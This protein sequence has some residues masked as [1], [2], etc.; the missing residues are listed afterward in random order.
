MFESYPV[1]TR[2]LHVDDIGG[3][4]HIYGKRNERTKQPPVDDF[5]EKC[6]TDVDA[7]ASIK[8][9]RFFFKNKY[10]WSTRTFKEPSMIR[11]TFTGLPNYM[12]RVDAVYEAYN[13]RKIWFFMG[14]EIYI[15][16]EA[17]LI[18]RK[19]LSD[20][21]ID[22]QKYRKIDA[23]F[24][25]NNRE[26]I[27]SGEVYWRLEKTYNSN[28][29]VEKG[30]PKDRKAV[31]KNVYDI[32]TAFSEDGQLN[33]FE[34]LYAYKFDPEKMSG[35]R[36]NLKN[37]ASFMDCKNIKSTI[38]NDKGKAHDVVHEYKQDEIEKDLD[39]PEKIIPTTE[40]EEDDDR[41]SMGTSIV[42]NYV[43]VL[44]LFILFLAL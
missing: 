41:P 2:T 1:G 10:M 17:R 40:T 21:G 25:F 43:V 23:I 8:K 35:D 44:A 13:D 9:E 7:V 5:P 16:E 11:D 30:Y 38:P 27:F 18:E 12:R 39:N 14:R 36:M 15:F 42:N 34:G 37:I 19:T 3:I 33:F 28:L 4:E 31:W 29:Q 24:R 6:Y 20:I 32:D 26:Y 22:Q